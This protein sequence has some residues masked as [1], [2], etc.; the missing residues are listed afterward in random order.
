MAQAK[1]RTSDSKSRSRHG[2]LDR[3]FRLEPSVSAWPLQEREGD[4]D[5]GS[6]RQ[7]CPRACGETTTK[8]G[9]GFLDLKALLLVKERLWKHRRSICSQI[10]VDA[11]CWRGLRL[12]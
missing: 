5:V 12:V 8:R 1:H 11:E 9:D 3:P 7:I 10:C 2:G 4:D 6:G